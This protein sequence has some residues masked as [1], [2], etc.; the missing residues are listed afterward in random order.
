MSIYQKIVAFIDV[1]DVDEEFNK[2]RFRLVSKL[3][4]LLYFILIVNLATVSYTNYGHGPFL[5]TV[6]IPGILCV[7]VA[8]RALTYFHARKE[9]ITGQMAARRLR[10]T[11]LMSMIL[12]IAFT[13][14]AL[15]I[16]HYGNVNTRSHAAFLICITVL[17]T[18]FCL[19]HLRQ[20]AVLLTLIVIPPITIT[21][22]LA[23][24]VVFSAIGLNLVLVSCLVLLVINRHYRDFKNQVEQRTTLEKQRE[25]LEGLNSENAL[26]ANQDSLTQLPNRRSFLAQLATLTEQVSIEQRTLVVGLLDLDGFK[27][28]NDVF[29]HSAGDRLLIQVGER[30]RD[31]LNDH[32]IIARLGGDEFGLIVCDLKDNDDILKLGRKICAAIKVPFE[33][34]EGT[35]QI[36]T[37]IGFAGFPDAAESPQELFERAD[38]ALYYS[39]EHNKGMPILFS[40]EHETIIREASAISQRLLEADIE[41]E[42]SVVFQPIV[43]ITT[44]RTVGMEAL[45]RWHSPV[46]GHVA[47]DV[48]IQAAERTG[49]IG[50]VTINLLTKALKH[51][52]QWPDDIIL[53]FNLSVLD[54]TSP[55]SI[56]RIMRL[57]ETSKFSAS[58]IVFEITESTVMQ[59][60]E[61]SCEA[62]QLLKRL[63]A[64][65]ALDD[66]G[67]GYSSLS[68]MQK[69]PIDRLKIDRSFIIGIE[70]NQMM[71]NIVRAIVSLCKD[72]GWDCVVEGIETEQQLKVL[73]RLGCYLIQGYYFSKPMQATEALDYVEVERQKPDALPNAVN[74]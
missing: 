59:D 41:E 9:E 15:S 48:F 38:Y 25:T 55:T 28:I 73:N 10:T 16:F 11:L 65:I 61:R 33:I 14:W 18:S 3:V 4:P 6:L 58:R 27:S 40:S 56:L 47:P 49:F 68:Y 2:A 44:N 43:D 36:A 50:Q 30:L 52:E 20:A 64:T 37:T 72:L 70:D 29:G 8:R 23:D 60:F 74:A 42:M 51:A 54:L 17:S 32:A 24:E 39:K 13:I 63:G 66:F 57:V 45:A 21:F 46:I 69:L 7:I 53:S 26:L 22:I 12:G 31:S 71:Q 34:N 19:V 62:L 5:L 1:S 67:T 35:V